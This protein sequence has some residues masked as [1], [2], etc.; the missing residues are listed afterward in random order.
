MGVLLVVAVVPAACSSG[1]SEAAPPPSTRIA[2]RPSLPF[3]VADIPPG[4]EVSRV[5]RGRQF[6]PWGDDSAGTAEPMTV[7]ARDGHDAYDS[8]RILVSVTGFRGNEGGLEQASAG[9]IAV[10]TREEFR[11]DGHRAIFV[12]AQRLSSGERLV[13]AD[14][15]VV[16]GHDLAVRVRAPGATRSELVGIARR[17]VMAGRTRAPEVRDP[18]AGYHVLGSV[19]AAVPATLNAMT[20]MMPFTTE[21]AFRTG[22]GNPV[23]HRMLLSSAST[24]GLLAVVTYPAT[25]ASLDAIPGLAFL[26]EP[27]MATT[28]PVPVGTRPGVLLEWG[29]SGFGRGRAVATQS[30][31][32][33]LILVMTWG[34]RP[35]ADDLVGLAASVTPISEEAWSRQVPSA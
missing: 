1:G 32:G 19:D 15:L 6:V 26:Y 18:P 16:R 9:Y 7:L 10:Q 35:G 21:V 14:L 24:G 23:V 13:R 28:R 8:E 25:V 20:G 30:A 17:V 3:A 34:A 29:D 27:D 11:V 5:E 33:N 2:S 4:Y 12:P 22:A 31:W